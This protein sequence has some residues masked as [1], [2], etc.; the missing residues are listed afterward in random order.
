M[1]FLEVIGIKSVTS[2]MEASAL[3]DGTVRVTR[4]SGEDIIFGLDSHDG[5]TKTWDAFTD[6]RDFS[7]IVP[8]VVTGDAK[9]DARFDSMTSEQKAQELGISVDEWKGIKA[10]VMAEFAKRYSKKNSSV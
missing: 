7:L 1:G 9:Q 10:I 3:E 2:K 8:S 5:T 4:E 6:T